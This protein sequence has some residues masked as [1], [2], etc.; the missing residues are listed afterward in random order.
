MLPGIFICHTVFIYGERI[1]H[2]TAGGSGGGIYQVYG[3]YD[4]TPFRYRGEEENTGILENTPN[5]V[6]TEER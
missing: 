4:T 6:E 1:T 2:N 5:D 3:R